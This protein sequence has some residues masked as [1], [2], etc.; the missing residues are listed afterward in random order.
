M[1]SSDVLKWTS[2]PNTVKSNTSATCPCDNPPIHTQGHPE[3][4]SS[5]PYAWKWRGQRPRS[6]LP[7]SKSEK[8]HSKTGLNAIYVNPEPLTTQSI[9]GSVKNSWLLQARKPWKYG[10]LCKNKPYERQFS[11]ANFQNTSVKISN[12]HSLYCELN[13]WNTFLYSNI[14]IPIN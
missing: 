6:H 3:H 4:L 1:D 2:V 8:L 7:S 11:N 9:E 13:G 10:S 5:S 14:Q 12:C